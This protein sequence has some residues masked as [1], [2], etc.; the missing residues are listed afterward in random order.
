MMNQP[1]TNKTHW[2][3]IFTVIFVVLI[4]YYL[5]NR[6]IYSYGVFNYFF[7]LFITIFI[8]L[9]IL[10]LIRRKKRV[11]KEDKTPKTIEHIGPIL[12]SMAYAKPYDEQVFQ[13]HLHHGNAEEDEEIVGEDAESSI[14]MR[15]PKQVITQKSLYDKAI[16]PF[17]YSEAL[18]EYLNDQ[19]ISIEK[20]NIRE[21][22]AALAA[23]KMTILKHD[24]AKVSERFIH[25]FSEFIGA[26]LFIDDLSTSKNLSQLWRADMSL[27]ACLISAQQKPELMYV[28]VFSKV[29]MTNLH[30]DL[31]PII[32]FAT[33]PGL[34]HDISS[35]TNGQIE[36]IPKNIWFIIIPK[37]SEDC[38][39]T[40]TILQA[41]ITLELNMKVVEPKEVVTQNP[42]K[43]SYENFINL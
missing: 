8:N 25:L 6:L 11:Y 36:D 2:K 33:N 22:F 3:R 26:S 37:K 31:N 23:S 14:R 42:I 29:D 5:I 20:N 28:M 40:D 7:N 10:W 39:M 17:K 43:L 35:I 12:D 15:K 24:Y 32:E 13:E 38:P 18:F 34:P 41:A 19:G 16:Q 30:K 1:N 4:N 21:M 9:V 27:K